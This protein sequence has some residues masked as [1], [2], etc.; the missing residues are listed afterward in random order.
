LLVLQFTGVL[1]I[2]HTRAL[3]AILV[4]LMLQAPIKAVLKVPGILNKGSL[5][6]QKVEELVKGK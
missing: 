2:G 5:S 4:L 6:I 3:T 1:H